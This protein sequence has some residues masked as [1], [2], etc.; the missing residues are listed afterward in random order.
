MGELL[1]QRSASDAMNE[2]TDKR[3]V[4]IPGTLAGA[5]TLLTHLTKKFPPLGRHHHSITLHQ[6]KLQL[7]LVHVAPCESVTFDAED[8]AKPV[9]QLVMEIVALV[10]KETPKPAA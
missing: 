1:R 4:P 2:E 7:N 6:G 3:L 8:L 10:P 5:Q 9:A